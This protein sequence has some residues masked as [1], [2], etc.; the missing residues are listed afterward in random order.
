MILLDTHTLVWFLTSPDKLSSISKHAIESDYRITPILVS[1]ISI[2]E[3]C[4]L[5]HRRKISFSVSLEDW[6][7]EL[8]KKIAFQFVPIDNAIAYE[9]QTLPSIFH[10]DPAD[11]FIVATARIMGA[12]LVT[13][14]AKI[15]R[16]KH[17][18]TIW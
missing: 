4:Q 8:N 9:S 7:A 18:Q 3:I 16:Y 13:K 2:W 5:I 6:L 15:R 17:V 14:D 10:K 11:R 1:S 12:K